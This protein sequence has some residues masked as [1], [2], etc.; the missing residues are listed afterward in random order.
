[1]GDLRCILLAS[2]A[3]KLHVI[4]I[5]TSLLIDT[6]YLFK[7]VFQAHEVRSVAVSFDFALVFIAHCHGRG[8]LYLSSHDLWHGPEHEKDESHRSYTATDRFLST[9]KSICFVLLEIITN[10]NDCM[11][12]D[13][14]A[15]VKSHFF[16]HL[17]YSVG[18]VRA[19]AAEL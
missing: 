2:E 9:L 16:S 8:S 5:G 18:D 3:L 6:S 19:V 4:V 11:Q 15:K 17:R 13:L 1:M 14:M 12:I 7:T 10:S